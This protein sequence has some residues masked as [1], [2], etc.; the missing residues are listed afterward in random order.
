MFL[1][2]HVSARSHNMTSLTHYFRFSRQEKRS[3]HRRVGDAFSRKE[4]DVGVEE[5]ECS[6]PQHRPSLCGF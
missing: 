4:E 3:R 6:E 2:M 1:D 5:V